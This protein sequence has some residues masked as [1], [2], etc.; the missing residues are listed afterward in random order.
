MSEFMDY[1]T[2]S[3]EGCKEQEKKLAQEGR[4]DEATLQKIRA[5]IYDICKT[6]Y[7]VWSGLNLEKTATDSY[8]ARLDSLRKSWQGAYDKARVH[9]AAENILVEETKL[10]VLTEVQKKFQTLQRAE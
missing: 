1:L 3:I 5:N 9:E 7:R 8:P 4:E 10:E 2:A 6:M